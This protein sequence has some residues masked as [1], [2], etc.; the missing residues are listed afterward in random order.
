[1]KYQVIIKKKIVVK[2]VISVINSAKEYNQWTA[3]IKKDKTKD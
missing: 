2:E 3:S 1:M